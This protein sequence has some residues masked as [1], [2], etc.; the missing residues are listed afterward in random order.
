M[1]NNKRVLRRVWDEN[2]N[3]IKMSLPLFSVIFFCLQLF[4]V[5]LFIDKQTY[6]YSI[7]GAVGVLESVWYYFM[8][9]FIGNNSQRKRSQLQF[10]RCQWKQNYWFL[11]QNIFEKYLLH[12]KYLTCR[13]VLYY[14]NEKSFKFS[15]LLLRPIWT[16]F[17]I[18]HIRQKPFL[19]VYFCVFQNNTSTLYCKQE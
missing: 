7:H 18:I 9:I 3:S 17:C 12:I 5:V 10:V 14:L 1:K 8:N 11:S 6:L 2:T 13:R 16:I 4:S 19:F 15:C